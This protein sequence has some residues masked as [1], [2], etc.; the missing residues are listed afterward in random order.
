MFEEVKKMLVDE[1]DVE[2]SA[3]TPDANLSADLGVNS[4]ELADFVLMCEDKYGISISDEEIRG[5]ITLN[6]VVNYLESRT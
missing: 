1:L 4:L 3:I 5:F 6:D 2:E